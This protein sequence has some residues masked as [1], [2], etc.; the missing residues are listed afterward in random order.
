MSQ[1]A[2]GKWSKMSKNL[3]WKMTSTKII[4]QWKYLNALNSAFW[5]PYG[6]EMFKENVCK[7]KTKPTIFAGNVKLL[8]CAYMHHGSISFF[9]MYGVR[10]KHTK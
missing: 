2:H 10:M 9:Y 1:I 7:M 5:E 6:M 4:I 3:P 8:V